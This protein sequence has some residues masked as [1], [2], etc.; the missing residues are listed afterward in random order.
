MQVYVRVANLRILL[1]LY[2]LLYEYVKTPPPYKN[3]GFGSAELALSS[4]CNLFF[5]FIHNLGIF[6]CK[7]WFSLCI[8]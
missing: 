2:R 6:W 7:P 1:F 3:I 8:V 4:T 5:E